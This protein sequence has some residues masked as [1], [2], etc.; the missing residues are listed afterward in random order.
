MWHTSNFG[1]VIILLSLGLGPIAKSRATKMYFSI[2]PNVQ[3][4]VI[5]QKL[6]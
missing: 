5:I 4:D 6:T 3:N 1:S 2:A